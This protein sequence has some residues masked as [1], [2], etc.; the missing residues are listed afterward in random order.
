[1]QKNKYKRL[2]NEERESIS[3]GIAQKISIREI[4]RGVC[5]AAARADQRVDRQGERQRRK[6]PG[7]GRAQ[8]AGHHHGRAQ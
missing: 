5:R 2:G 7:P 4:A 8:R 6:D 3:R 1:M